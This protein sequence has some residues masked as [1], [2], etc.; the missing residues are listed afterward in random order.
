MKKILYFIAICTVAMSSCKKKEFLVEDT[1][2]QKIAPGDPQ[3][4][5]L[6]F[7]NVTPGSPVVNYYVNGVKFSSALSTSGKETGGYT[8]NGLYPDLG[9][10][11]TT[12]GAIA[13]TANII[14]TAT[15][16]PGLEVLT[17]TLTPVAGKYYTVFTTGRYSATNKSIGPL[18]ALEDVRPAL[19][20]AKIFIRMV[21]LYNGSPNLD[22]IKVAT[23]TKVAAN[24]AYGTASGFV[25]I[26]VPGNG[27]A[28]PNIFAL[29][30]TATNLP[31]LP[32]LTLT[33]TKGRA[34]TFYLRGVVG[35]PLFLP[36]G[37]VYT[38][39]Y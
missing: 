12:P 39:F 38:T 16:D 11:I 1:Q 21:N 19:D 36:G 3:Y 18:L 31:I 33:L 2:Y 5:Y 8:Y 30:N 20:T 23:N 7:L 29:N 10:A 14:P 15:V 34:Y 37:T 27:I 32:N 13:V 9:Y 24:V 6:K 4:S 25:E 22:L 17:T 26:P 35:D 28:P